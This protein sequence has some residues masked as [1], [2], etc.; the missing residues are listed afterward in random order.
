M[1]VVGLEY[2]SRSTG[3]PVRG[4]V[5]I[6]H[7][8]GQPSTLTVEALGVCGAA[9]GWERGASRCARLTDGRS[10]NNNRGDSYAPSLQGTTMPLDKLSITLGESALKEVDLRTTFGGA[11]RSGVISRDLDRYYEAL[12]RARAK[13]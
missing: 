1:T 12:K 11:N 13:L 4:R 2:D 9:S 10:I 5:T 8:K 3:R 6:C 7:I